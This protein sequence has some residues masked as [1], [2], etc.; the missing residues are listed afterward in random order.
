M[1]KQA[2]TDSPALVLI[3]TIG[4][5]AGIWR[6]L[7]DEL[8][9]TSFVVTVDLP[10]HGSAPPISGTGRM[11]AL[12]TAVE[13]A[14]DDA[15]VREAV[16]LGHGVGGLVAQG[17]AVKRLDLVRGLILSATAARI[18]FSGHWT[19][20]AHGLRDIGPEALV[21]TAAA[22]WLPKGTDPEYVAAMIRRQSAK[23]MAQAAEA[24]AGSDFYTTTAT[25]RLPTLALVGSLDHVTPPDLVRETAALVPG[26]DVQIITGAGHL[27]MLDQ[28][29]PYAS[30]VRGFLDRIGHTAPRASP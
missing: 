21:S 16:V 4:T 7:A 22:T 2:H 13:T 24:A 14:L 12:I 17:L 8:D 26:S 9:A 23:A 28:P 25:L 30:A 6:R 3:G 11:G 15:G 18:G 10:G 20:L 27:S 5:D 19:R 29:E 1:A